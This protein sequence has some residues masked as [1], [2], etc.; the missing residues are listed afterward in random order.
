LTLCGLEIL[1]AHTSFSLSAQELAQNLVKAAKKAEIEYQTAIN[2]SYAQ[3]SDTTF[4]AL[5]R[6][7]PIT[8]NKLDWNKILTYKIGG[9]LSQK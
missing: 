9:E 1:E 4:K 3:L 5:R 7:L 2:E 8:R 6:A